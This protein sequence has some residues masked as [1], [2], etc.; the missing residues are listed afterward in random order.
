MRLAVG[1]GNP[2]KRRAVEQA[3]EATLDGPEVEAVPVDS[4]VAEQPAGREETVTGA[5]TRAANA[6]AA[7][8]YDLGVGLEGGVAEVEGAE[9]LFL[10]MWVAV[11]DGDQVGVGSGPSFRLPDAIGDRVAAGEELGPV[12]DDVLGEDGVAR[13]Q[14][15]AGALSGGVV[16][17]DDAL[18]A[19]VAAA[20]GPFVTDRY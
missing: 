6:L 7:G 16:D 17:R 12:M 10:I 5:K 9:G 11:T 20:M 15:A 8:E 1:S 2:V 13:R 18:A 3:V 4:G 14:G 19:G